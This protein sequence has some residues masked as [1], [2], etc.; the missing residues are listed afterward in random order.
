MWSSPVE[1][2]RA[3]RRLLDSGFGHCEL[4]I[5]YP[6]WN[7]ARPERGNVGSRRAGIGPSA[8]LVPTESPRVLPPTLEDALGDLGLLD[9]EEHPF[10]EDVRISV[11]CD[12][13]ESLARVARILGARD[14]TGPASARPH[15]H[16]AWTRASRV[17]SGGGA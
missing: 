11:R 10:D 4:S 17:E 9:E 3:V 16:L 5:Y 14:G 7:R 12:D 8:L 15:G 6:R 1:I 2:Q 13:E